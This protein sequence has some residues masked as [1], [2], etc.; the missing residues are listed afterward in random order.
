LSGLRKFSE[1]TLSDKFKYL[2]DCWY[3]LPQ[4]VFNL[5]LRNAIAHNNV[6][7][8]QAAQVV[9]YFPDGGRLDKS[10]GKCLA[11]LDFMRLLLVAF[12]EMHNLHHVIKSLYYYKFLIY[13]KH[14]AVDQ[15]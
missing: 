8:D 5:G 6:L 15:S 14:H 13:D 9:T 1:K 3:N 7:Y 4:Y 2:D 10:Q 11:F 12:R